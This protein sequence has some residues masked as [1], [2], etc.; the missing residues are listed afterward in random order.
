MYIL[1]Q[2]K[3]VKV[4]QSCPTL[5]PHRPARLHCPWEF[6]GK[7][8]KVGCHSLLQR[9]FPTQGLN[10]DLLPQRQVFCHLSHNL[11]ILFIKFKSETQ[12]SS[13]TGVSGPLLRV[14]LWW[15]LH[16]QHAALLS[17]FLP[18]HPPLSSPSPA[19]SPP[20]L[21]RRLG[22]EAP[23]GR[24]PTQQGCLSCPPRWAWAGCGCRL[25]S[26]PWTPGPREQDR[27]VP[28]PDLVGKGAMVNPRN[29]SSE[30]HSEE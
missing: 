30:P 9:I 13:D 6:P 2:P 27:L 1:P 14:P 15:R 29:S 11:S 18:P 28:G 26:R 19:L 8:T 7:N 4:A 3:H 25:A 12:P 16:R 21:R 20:G 22:A 23:P 17:R 24:V 10:P 5:Q